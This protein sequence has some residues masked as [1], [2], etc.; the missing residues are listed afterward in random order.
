MY[1]KRYYEIAPYSFIQT[2]F[3]IPLGWGVTGGGSKG[4]SKPSHVFWCD[5]YRQ[6]AV[7]HRTG[8][9][10]TNAALKWR[11]STYTSCQPRN[12]AEKSPRR[13]NTECRTAIVRPSNMTVGWPSNLDEAPT[14]C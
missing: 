14:F 12:T 5:S 11:A 1:M 3:M 2:P 9:R 4:T 10:K 6:D 8:L 13:V 7:H